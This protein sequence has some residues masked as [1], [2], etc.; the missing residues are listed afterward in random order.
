MSTDTT[1]QERMDPQ[2]KAR[3]TA[4][5][6]SG[7]YTQ[8]HGRLRQIG[9]GKDYFCCLGVLCEL[10]HEEGAVSRFLNEGS[11]RYVYSGGYNDAS[12]TTLPAVVR[13][14]AHMSPVHNQ[15]VNTLMEMNDGTKKPDGSYG[16]YTFSEIAD[17]ID[18]NL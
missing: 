2:I 4:A 14:W 17:W 9:P 10:A 11:S 8:G 7:D 16:I 3:W 1:V 5:L 15:A 6:R 12:P 13:N 18:E